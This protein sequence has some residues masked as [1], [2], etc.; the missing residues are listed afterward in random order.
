MPGFLR[1]VNV[2]LALLGR[3]EM[4]IGSYRD[5]ESTYRSHLQASSKLLDR[6]K[7][8][9]MGLEYHCFTVLFGHPCNVW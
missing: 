1:H 6:L 7:V 5:F 8:A 2:I 9:G 4:D 3:Y